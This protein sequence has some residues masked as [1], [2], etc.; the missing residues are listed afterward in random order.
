MES[1]EQQEETAQQMDMFHIA[2]TQLAD[3]ISKL[4]VMAMT[5]IEALQTLFEIAEKG[6]R[7]VNRGKEEVYAENPTVGCKNHQ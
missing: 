2:E 6:K 4:D 7:V 1:K 5:P 3:E